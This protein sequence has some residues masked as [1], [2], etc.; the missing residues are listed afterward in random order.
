MKTTF[1][2][3]VGTIIG[4][5]IVIFL[6]VGS[7]LIERYFVTAHAENITFTTNSAQRV[8]SSDG[9]SAQYLI[10]TD[11]GVFTDTDTIWYWKWNSSDVYN[12]AQK[13]THTCLVAGFRVPFLSWYRNIIRCQS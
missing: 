9:S 5:I 2:E 6:I 13:G 8:V 11:K 3:Y 1:Y 10:Y 4:G 7:V 12:Q